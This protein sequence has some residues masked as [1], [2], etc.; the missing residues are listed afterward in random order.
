MPVVGA[1]GEDAVDEDC[2]VVGSVVCG[3][4]SNPTWQSG[5]LTDTDVVADLS[6]PTDPAMQ[7]A[8]QDAIDDSWLDCWTLHDIMDRMRDVA[9]VVC[10]DGTRLDTTCVGAPASFPERVVF[11]EG[12]FA[13]GPTTEQGTL[14][15]LGTL[16]I[17]GNADWDGLVL[18]IGEGHYVLN[19]AGNGELIGGLVVANIAGP[20][21]VYGNDDDC[22]GGVGGFNHA[23]FDE[24]GGGN[25]G[26]TYCSTALIDA[27]PM[28]PYDVVD[29][30][31]R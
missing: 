1:V 13:V 23:I 12:D 26:A 14:A 24:R 5:A 16:H 31:Q 30:L 17:S 11:A 21:G 25:A 10:A 20:D 15:V 2:P 6:D 28:M 7:Q 9:D 27:N 19:G 22:T 3:M 18:V 4:E 8:G 29:F